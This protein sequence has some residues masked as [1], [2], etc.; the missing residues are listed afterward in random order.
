MFPSVNSSAGRVIRSFF[1]VL[2]SLAIASCGGSDDPTDPGG[3][4]VEVPPAPTNVIVTAGNQANIVTWSPASDATSYN[5]YWKAGAGATTGDTKVAGVASPYTHSPISN[6]TLYSYVV[7][8]Q[9]S[10]GE[11]SASAAVDGTPD[12]PPIYVSG[13]QGN[14]SNS[15]SSALPVKTL[16]K[17][18]ELVDLEG[19][20]E[21]FVEEGLYSERPELRPGVDI[22]GGYSFPSWEIG[23]ERSVFVVGA[24]PATAIGINVPTVFERLEF[25]A[26]DNPVGNSV[27][28]YADA[29]NE[30]LQFINCRFEAGDGKVGNSGQPYPPAQDGS[31]G[32]TGATNNSDCDNDGG[33]AGGAGGA[34]GNGVADCAGGGGGK[35]GN[36]EGWGATGARGGCGSSALGGAGGGPGE[37]AGHG[38]AG[39]DGTDG[40]DGANSAIPVAD[41][42]GQ[43]VAKQW[44]PKHP[45]PGQDGGIAFSGGGGGGG[46]GEDCTFF[47]C[48]DGGGAGGGGG[49]GGG[50]EGLGGRAAEAGFGSFAVFLHQ[51]PVLFSDCTFVSGNGGAGGKGG[52]GQKGG[53]GG[54]GVI[55][56]TDSCS[57]QGNGGNG[58]KGGNGGNGGGAAGGAG[59]PSYG[60]YVFGPAPSLQSP[61]FE[62]GTPGIGGLGGAKGSGLSPA[63]PGSAGL[64]GRSNLPQL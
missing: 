30:Q 29:S 49:G 52:D 37:P 58:G 12:L 21:I 19:R 25:K 47:L 45:G 32:L 2:F 62:L 43:I 51:S 48:N 42:Q 36:Q 50:L 44:A 64:V 46:G 9:N 35:G 20:T 14:D 5:L 33:Q 15:G 31:I 60:I 16:S 53:Q 18:Y 23:T 4:A 55:G 13:T 27:A 61:T 56:G 17:A 3:G 7:T 24:E 11:S 59:G 26:S 54:E 57:Q 41:N 34:H 1:L 40:S 10:A 8:A 28:F 6:G 39:D 63:P 38:Q 22:R